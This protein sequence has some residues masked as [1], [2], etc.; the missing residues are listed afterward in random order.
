MDNEF[1]TADTLP[2]G[3]H[4]DSADGGA[5]GSDVANLKDVLGKALGK[6]FPSDEVALKSVKDTFSYV[7]K[8]GQEIASLKQQ[9]SSAAQAP[10]VLGKIGEIESKLNE[11]TFYAK[12]PELEQYKSVISRFGNNPEEAVKNP[13]AQE[14]LKKLQVAD[15]VDKSK[16]VLQS[17]PRLGLTTDKFAKAKESLSAGK[18]T[19]AKSSAVSGVIDAFEMR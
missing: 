2:D 10:D 12:H 14:I 16:S 7:G 1:N 5:A 8:A 9:L 6:E 18:V 13:E 19:E 11:T 4:V 3:T 17:N 15:E